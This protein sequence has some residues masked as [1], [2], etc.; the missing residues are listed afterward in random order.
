MV[1]MY[2]HIATILP[3]YKKI[4]IIVKN[5]FNPDFK[6]TTININNISTIKLNRIAT[7]ISK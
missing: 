1:Q 7:A 4:P 5:T 3:L 2:G 6:G